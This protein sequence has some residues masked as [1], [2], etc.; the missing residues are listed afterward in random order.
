MSDEES[1]SPAAGTWNRYNPNRYYTCDFEK[2]EKIP[3]V[4]RSHL[5]QHKTSL[6]SSKVPA[7]PCAKDA[8]FTFDR[9]IKD[10]GEWKDFVETYISSYPRAMSIAKLSPRGRPQ[11]LFID[12]ADEDNGE[13]KGHVSAISSEQQRVLDHVTAT[14]RYFSVVRIDGEAGSGKSHLL[15]FFLRMGLRVTYSTTTKLLCETTVR[16]FRAAGSITCLTIC[17]LMMELFLMPPF[18]TMLMGDLL[19]YVNGTS[20]D[21][22]KRELC[23]GVNKDCKYYWNLLRTLVFSGRYRQKLPDVI[24][25]DE[26]SLLSGSTIAV[27]IR[28]IRETYKSRKVVVIFAGDINQIGPFYCIDSTTEY[29]VLDSK[30]VFSVRF[31]TQHRVVDASYNAFLQGIQKTISPCDYIRAQ[32]S[33]SCRRQIEYNYPFKKIDAMPT[34]PK[35]IPKWFDDNDIA[36]LLPFIIFAYS[37]QEVHHYNISLAVS[38]AS[39]LDKFETIKKENYINFHIFKVY[40]DGRPVSNYQFPGQPRVTV[41]PLIMGF[42]YKVLT[43][44][45][46]DLPRS[47]IVYMLGFTRDYATVYNPDKRTIHHIP[48]MRCNMNLMYTPIYGFPLQLHA[49]DTFFSAQGLTITR[50]IYANFSKASR[51]EAYVILSRIR[52]RDKCKSIYIPN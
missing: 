15:N 30:D 14:D 52:S 2:F 43:R 45:I 42:P 39:G 6:S 23:T 19:P 5:Q 16:K 13:A 21:S 8:Y 31:N 41:L 3:D 24:F 49:A 27:L 11:T 38:I 20:W 46:E 29:A 37:N 4:I 9:V 26:Y 34:T 48:V 18:P 44:D 50:D 22:C 1:S 10:G 7:F 12:D 25:I 28:A 51:E 36:H 47:T 17:K 33:D 32:F 40:V 35:E